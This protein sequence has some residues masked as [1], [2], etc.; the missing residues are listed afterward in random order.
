[1]GDYGVERLT[2][3]FDRMPAY[4]EGLFSKYGDKNFNYDP[5]KEGL[6]FAINQ[7]DRKLRLN[8]GNEGG[9]TAKATLRDYMNYDMAARFAQAGPYA[10]GADFFAED[11]LSAWD[12]RKVSEQKGA[13]EVLQQWTHPSYS[14]TYSGKR[15]KHEGVNWEEYYKRKSKL[16]RKPMGC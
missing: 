3:S 2:G 5:S 8:W 6:N 16:A 4:Y 12:F 11:P 10:Q 7:F 14:T 9:A 15:D 13:S 1:M